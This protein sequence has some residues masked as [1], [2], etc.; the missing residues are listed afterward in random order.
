M[1]KTIAYNPYGSRWMHHIFLI[2]QRG[3]AL[4]PTVSLDRSFLALDFVINNSLH[5]FISN[6]VNFFQKFDRNYFYLLLFMI[7]KCP[8]C[9]QRKEL[10]LTNFQCSY[11]NKIYFN[12]YSTS[13]KCNTFVIILHFEQYQNQPTNLKTNKRIC[14][15]VRGALKGEDPFPL[16][17]RWWK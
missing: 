12:C 11:N 1:Y 2:C 8:S 3:E 17:T 15:G 4:S 16:G 6:L 5:H 13:W 10:S 7:C 14:V 9:V